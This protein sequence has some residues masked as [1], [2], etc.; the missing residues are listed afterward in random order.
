MISDKQLAANRAN[1]NFSTGPLTL[2]GKARTRY[3]AVTHALTGQLTIVA[4]SEQSAFTG[5]SDR[6]TADL[7]P[8]G[9]QELQISARIVRD[10]WRLHRAAAHE[11]NIFALGFVETSNTELLAEDS[12]SAPDPDPTRFAF[13]N[14]KTFLSKLRDFNLAGLYAQRIHRSLMKD[15]A[16]FRQLQQERKRLETKEETKELARPRPVVAV[17]AA[18]ANGSA[19]STSF[20]APSSHPGVRETGPQ[21]VNSAAPRICPPAKTPPQTSPE[22]AHAA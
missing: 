16:L 22:A 21:T 2:E 7:K 3:N 18:A 10:T 12:G 15:Y 8:C 1:A 17:K 6:L 20:A 13:I 19:F 14:A 11:E 4:P 5:L 9:E